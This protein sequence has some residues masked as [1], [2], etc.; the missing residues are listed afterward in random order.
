MST[1]TDNNPTLQ[2]MRELL[3]EMIGQ[4]DQ[5]AP[6]T[7]IVPPPAPASMSMRELRRYG[8]SYLAKVS[9]AQLIAD[10]ITAR[11][12]KSA[13]FVRTR[14]NDTLERRSGRRHP[15]NGQ[16]TVYTGNGLHA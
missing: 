6:A 14:L 11:G 13:A 3:V 2:A 4:V 1:T 9:N 16:A 7:V 15:N 12:G 10:L 8:V 5:A